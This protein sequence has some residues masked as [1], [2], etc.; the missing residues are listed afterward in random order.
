[1]GWAEKRV[2]PD[3]IKGAY[4]WR[5][6]LSTGVHLPLSSDFPG[7]TLN[8]FYG[9]Y[10]AVTRQNTSGNPP[11][12]WYPAE[13]LTLGEALRGYTIEGAYSEFE[14][15]AK[16]SI[17]KGKLA[18]L[19]VIEQEISALPPREILSIRVLKTIVGGKVVYDSERK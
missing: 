7:E 6:L 13:T 9:I 11:G 15:Q 4:A 3:R 2:R 17:E 16:G 12:G 14:E 8:P 19:T 10:A 18:D 1:M 5:S